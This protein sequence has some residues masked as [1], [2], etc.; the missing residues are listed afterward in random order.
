MEPL[1]IRCK[2]RVVCQHAIAT[3]LRPGAFLFSLPRTSILAQSRFTICAPRITFVLY[4]LVVSH[5]PK[6]QRQPFGESFAHCLHR[7]VAE[8]MILVTERLDRR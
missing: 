3:L 5:V 2:P 7:N 6:G 4:L 8:K 1:A